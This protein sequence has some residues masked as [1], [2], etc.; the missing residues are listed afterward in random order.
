MESPQQDVVFDKCVYTIVGS[1]VIENAESAGS[2]GHFT[3]GKSWAKALEL[4]QQANLE[5]KLLLLLLADAAHI[6]GVEWIAQIVGIEISPDGSTKVSFAGLHPLEDIRPR[7]DLQ[8]LSTG[9]AMSNSYIRPYA[10]CITPDFAYDDT[11]SIL[12]ISDSPDWVAI[13]KEALNI[14][15]PTINEGQRKMLI[16]HYHAPE[17][18]LSVKRLAEIAGYEGAKTGSLHYGKLARKISEAIGEAPSGDQISMIAEWNGDKKDERGHGQWILYDEVAQALEELGWVTKEINDEQAPS[19]IPVP[20]DEAEVPSET[21]YKAWIETR[22]G[23]QKFRE[24]LLQ[25]WR[26]CSVTGCS[27]QEILIASHI[28]PWSVASNAE[29]LDVSNGLLLTPNLDKLFDNYFISFNV[30]GEIL[31]SKII[32]SKAKSD[33]GINPSMKLRRIEDKL[34]QFL[35]RH[36]KEFL[37]RESIR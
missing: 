11:A 32:S 19:Y 20:S 17:M 5:N 37:E 16:G 23:Q 1:D 10:L 7:S 14:I 2:E 28:V 35:G 33:L 34:L 3:E 27:L 4:L 30:R 26:G 18:S 21:S 6:R 22:I 15:E 9:T 24:K 13:F 12:E 29:R 25:H 36:E 31:I 8:L